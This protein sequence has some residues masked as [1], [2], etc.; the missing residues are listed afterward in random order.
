MLI[1]LHQLVPIIEK[2]LLVL[3]EGPTK[4]INDS[5]GAAEEKLVSTLVKQRQKFRFTL[6]RC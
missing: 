3:G 2:W 6:H 1:I 5:V 4:G